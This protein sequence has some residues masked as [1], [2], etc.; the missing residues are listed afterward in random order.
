M[1]IPL[2]FEA[3]SKQCL[4]ASGGF[5]SSYFISGGIQYGYHVFTG[6]G[7]FTVYNGSLKAQLLVVGGGGGG[8]YKS[9]GG[10][11][12]GGGG[13]VF[14][15][16]AQR[17]YAGTYS[18]GIGTGGAGGILGS[19]TNAANGLS[20]S[21][22]GPAMSIGVGGG[23]GAVLGTGGPSGNGFSGGTGVDAGAAEGGGGGGGAVSAG[24]S[25]SG[26]TPSIAGDGGSG[27]TMSVAN[28]VDYYGCGG[29]G[30]SPTSGN[31]NGLSCNGLYGRGNGD[32][33]VGVGNSGAPNRGGGGGGGWVAGGAG[34]EGIVIIQYVV[35][36]Y[37]DNFFNETGS[38]GCRQ[39]TFDRTTG[40]Y[41]PD[42]VG[43]YIYLPCGETT[44][45]TGSIESFYPITVCA[46]S[47]SY[48]AY[49]GINGTVFS[50]FANSGSSTIRCAN[51]LPC[52]GPDVFVPNCSQS[53]VMA[54]LDPVG[55]TS[56]GYFVPR[57]SGSLGSLAFSQSVAYRCA[58]TASGYPI[59]TI[60]DNSQYAR[61]TCLQYNYSG[62]LPAGGANAY[63]T[64]YACGGA[65]QYYYQESGRFTDRNFSFNFCADVSF[66]GPV[67]GSDTGDV[68]TLAQYGNCLTGS[69]LPVCGCP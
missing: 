8:A 9:G 16:P 11:G 49:E 59:G 44:Y 58:V 62:F 66:G 24:E 56:I 46:A 3:T 2:T 18:I 47:N 14:Y 41:T 1:Y 22:N 37:C 69:L 6:S 27:F 50:G 65:S 55:G 32:T 36:D 20:S 57:N 21:I 53:A 67:I 25:V 51:D 19:A 30:G 26:L 7:N 39:L 29:G 68:G 43:D 15:N 4:I 35:N 38:C 42:E 17:F 54:F 45:V 64:Y 34:G 12:G 63:V 23:G 33:L 48:F 60:G 31:D 28:Y 5:E 13:Q 40:A 52:T 10:A 61:A